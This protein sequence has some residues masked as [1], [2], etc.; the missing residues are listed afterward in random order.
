MFVCD[1]KE[2]QWFC[3]VKAGTIADTY[4]ICS[5]REGENIICMLITSSKHMIVFTDPVRV[6]M[7]NVP[8]GF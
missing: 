3:D 5:R 6:G 4:H 1:C 7:V 8:D 2:V